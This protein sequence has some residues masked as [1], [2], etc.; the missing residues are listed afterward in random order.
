MRTTPVVAADDATMI[1][2]AGRS[3]GTLT[4]TA[5]YTVTLADLLNAGGHLFVYFTGASASDLTLPTAANG[6]GK[7]ITMFKPSGDTDRYAFL[8]TGGATIEG[9]TANKRFANATNELGA[10]TIISDGTN[11]RVVSLKGTFAVDNS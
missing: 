11:W 9:S 5:S 3:A 4:K 1:P 10:C 2:A 7:F 6:K 8:A